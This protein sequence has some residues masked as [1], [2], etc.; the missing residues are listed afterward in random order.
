MNAHRFRAVVFDLD[1][2]LVDSMPM[3]L[4]GYA[5][6]L[7]PSL[8][9]L[10]P[11]EILPRLGGP[12]QRFFEET[13]VDPIQSAAALAR[14]VEF[15][16]EHW[17]LIQPF[18]GATELLGQLRLA[19]VSVG[20]WTGRD[21]VSTEQ[22]LNHHGLAGQV[23]EIV[24]GDDLPSH[25]PDPEGLR[26]VLSRLGVTASEALFVGDA[27]VDLIAGARAGVQ[28]VL[29]RHDR[30]VPREI[31]QLAIHTVDT[32]SGAYHWIMDRLALRGPQPADAKI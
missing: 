20:V 32:P 30:A 3:V 4:R 6:A 13:I 31:E 18:P 26:T 15:F 8:G 28:T 9:P 23:A 24:C 27:D 5:H 19:G 21:R 14:L 11:E 2:T 25:K 16:R 17:D 1:G 22:I 12:P 29:I 7:A 10:T